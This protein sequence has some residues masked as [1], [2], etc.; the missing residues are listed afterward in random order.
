M[1]KKSARGGVARD[2]PK[3][4]LAKELL[5][6]AA[7]EW[8]ED[9]SKPKGLSFFVGEDG[10]IWIALEFISESGPAAVLFNPRQTVEELVGACQRRL[11]RL[12]GLESESLYERLL[13]TQVSGSIA[14]MLDILRDHFGDSVEELARVVTALYDMKVMSPPSY[15]SK[16]T[17][18]SSRRQVFDDL[19]DHIIER[20]RERFGIEGRGRKEAVTKELVDNAIEILGGNPSQRAVARFIGV[21]PKTVREWCKREG[22]AGWSDFIEQSR[23]GRK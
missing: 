17:P 18:P 15:D 2:I 16:A 21:P 11:G 14:I 1:C 9:P 8:L 13:R 6:K 7:A 19:L 4:Q 23:G 10:E 20:R 3:T 22:Y 12:E 5:E